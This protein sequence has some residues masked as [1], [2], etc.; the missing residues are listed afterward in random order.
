MKAAS[1][2]NMYYFKAQHVLLFISISV[3]KA[4]MCKVKQP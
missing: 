2:G 4:E 1:F 3:Q